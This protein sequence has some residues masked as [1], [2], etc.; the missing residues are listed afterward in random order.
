MADPD[1]MPGFRS[2]PETTLRYNVD[3]RAAAVEAEQWGGLRGAHD[4]VRKSAGIEPSD[5]N[6]PLTQPQEYLAM[7][8]LVAARLNAAEQNGTELPSWATSLSDVS[9]VSQEEPPSGDTAIS[10]FELIRKD[11]AIAGAFMTRGPMAR[12]SLPVSAQVAIAE[13]MQHIESQIAEDPQLANQPQAAAQILRSRLAV[14]A[15]DF[16]RQLRG[17]TQVADADGAAAR[18]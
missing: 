10:G 7:L 18:A 17:N 12:M 11:G 5:P 9:L 3:Y 14:N 4:E 15:P 2:D 16:A 8:A 1:L 13:A 6:V